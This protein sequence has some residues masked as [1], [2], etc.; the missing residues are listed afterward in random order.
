MALM[1]LL[2]VS[3]MPA[4]AQFGLSG[5]DPAQVVTIELAA[6][7][8]KA[9]V[10]SVVKLQEEVVKLGLKPVGKP[11]VAFVDTDDKGFRYE[12][13]IPLA[14]KPEPAPALSEGLRIASSPAG[15]TLRFQHRGTYEDIE[16]TYEMITAYL[17]EKGL[18]AQNLF[19][20]EYLNL[21]RTAE[22][23]GAQVDI[24]VFL[25]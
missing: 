6:R 12:A 5:V 20:E 1:A 11:I 22:E 7:P 2:I 19:V 18:E 17:D 16:T 3:A 25:K 9:V 10:A 4:Q 21:P 24:Y 23:E 8:L 14:E 13:M 15:K